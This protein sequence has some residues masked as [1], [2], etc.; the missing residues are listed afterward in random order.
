MNWNT[1]L[2]LLK[3]I[4][5]KLDHK[6]KYY[7]LDILAEV[8]IEDGESDVSFVKLTN[9]ELG[10]DSPCNS[11][12]SR[13]RALDVEDE[14]F[15]TNKIEIKFM[16]NNDEIQVPSLPKLSGDLTTIDEES[17]RRR[18][19]DAEESEMFKKK[20]IGTVES[21]ID[22]RMGSLTAESEE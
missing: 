17:S 20:D 21:D 4:A 15:S 11:E 16:M 7:V 18:I 5:H 6:M 13:E 8:K 22:R 1:G 14:D 12:R 2:F 10:Q 3:K 9:F 19:V